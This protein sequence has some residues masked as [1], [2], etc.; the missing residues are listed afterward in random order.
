MMSST[1]T[2]VLEVTKKQYF[3]KLNAFVGSF[4]ALLLVHFIA[5]LFSFMGSG[6]MGT[7]SDELSLNVTYYTGNGI[8]MFT[9][10]WAFVTGVTCTT[11][12]SKD[13]DFTFVT[14]RLTSHLSNIAFLLTASVIAGLTAMLSSI[15][16]KVIIYF[17]VGLENV[18]NHSIVVPPLE[19][20][21]G[22]IAMV[23]YVFLLSGLGY[24]VGSIVQLNKVFVAVIPGIFVGLLF[25]EAR[26]NGEGPL[27]DIFSFFAAENSLIIFTLK[28]L[29]TVALLLF[30]AMVI[31]NEVE[32]RR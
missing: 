8:L 7:G 11:K 13:G 2:N 25:L 27:S 19:L 24:L 1:I 12:Q 30:T 32:V 4:S 20:L 28:T 15:V 18:V 17:Y 5:L 29:M 10:I 23:L 14:N 6:S 9:L 22:I 3:F 16:I 31:S 21:I 26:L